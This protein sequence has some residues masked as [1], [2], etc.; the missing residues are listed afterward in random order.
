MNIN[1]YKRNE[2]F[3]INILTEKLH[4]KTQYISLPSEI[5]F[6]FCL[7]ETIRNLKLNVD[8][9]KINH[10]YLIE[11]FYNFLVEDKIFKKIDESEYYNL[12]NYLH[13]TIGG[14]TSSRELYLYLVSIR[15]IL[16]KK[17]INSL[18][19]EI[20]KSLDNENLSYEEMNFL[21]N[22][23]LN[24][25][26]V[27]RCCYRCLSLLLDEFYNDKF[28]NLIDFIRY[29]YGYYDENVEILVPIKNW[30]K[31]DINFLIKFN[32]IEDINNIKYL[33]IYENG[34]IDYISLFETHKK[35]IDSVLNLIKFYGSSN[36][37]YCYENDAIV[38]RRYLNDEFLIPLKNI[39]VYNPFM[40][41]E[42][43]REIS[44]QTLLTLSDNDNMSLYYAINDILAYAE[45]DNDILSSAS[46]VDNWIA[47]ESLIKLS[48]H[49]TG[50]EGVSLYIPKMLS[51][52]FFRKDLNTL[53]KVVHR[54][55]SVER[56]VELVIE[57]K[58]TG[59][60]SKNEYLKWKLSKYIDIIKQPKLLLQKL[61]L[62]EKTIEK[63]LK[64]IYIIRNEYVHS[65]NIDAWNNTSKLKIKH[66]LSFSL[67][68]FFKTLNS[69]IKSDHLNVTGEQVF[70]DIMKN[71][72]NR[73]N[74]LLA[75]NGDFKINDKKIS[76]DIV[77]ATLRKYQIIT[78]IILNR[79]N[80]LNIYYDNN[81]LVNIKSNY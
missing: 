63:D 78:N 5:C 12:L 4:H 23:F 49:K 74:V 43:L 67:D 11:D 73:Q 81:Q 71:Y 66:L 22:T 28:E 21:Y 24:E 80:S 33:K 41:S 79:R 53:L 47:L 45:R 8:N 1:D 60:H 72:N 77:G 44:L 40:G 30:E 70:S 17:Y 51:I 34:E 2:Q 48:N 31:N 26:I 52:D 42:G 15:N 36:I 32:Q 25:I 58:Y 59:S 9:P 68:T 39:T 69:N 14:S 3:L 18:Y 38:K 27:N 55:M 35:R 7:N 16:G 65:S 19:D 13:R 20:E 37:D 56:F 64:R 57:E 61:N 29:L 6:T 62:I 50:I 10:L 54:N 75:I 76:K 46:F